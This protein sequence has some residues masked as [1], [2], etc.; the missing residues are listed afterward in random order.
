MSEPTPPN[1]G[2]P[3]RRRRQDKSEQPI[4]FLPRGNIPAAVSWFCAV[5]GLIPPLGAAT[6]GIAFVAGWIGRRRSLA[7][8]ERK[9]YS[10]STVGAVLGLAEVLT[11]S[12]GLYLLR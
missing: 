2:E 8:P 1:P 10:H 9:G 7:D 11:Q 6:G 5:V 12:L 4:Q 3:R